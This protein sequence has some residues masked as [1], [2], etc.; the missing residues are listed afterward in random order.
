MK[1]IEIAKSLLGGEVNLAIVRGNERHT[2]SERGISALLG[3]SSG[4]GKLLTGAAV[5]DAVVGRA[6][7]MLMAAGGAAE[8]YAEVLS[9]GAAEV[10]R[11]RGIPFSCGT[12][13]ERIINR[14]GT[15]ICPMERAVQGVERAEDAVPVLQKA[16]ADLQKKSG[17]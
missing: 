2:Y 14:A 16:L 15:D 7:A 13:T 8:V 1:E 9:E 4:G 10:F 12:L 3:I 6:A 17:K 5:A 11:R